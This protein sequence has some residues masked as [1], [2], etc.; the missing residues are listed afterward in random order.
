MAQKIR[1]FEIEFHCNLINK[2]ILT[3]KK[4]IGMKYPRCV[5]YKITR[6]NSYKKMQQNFAHA[7]QNSTKK[8]IATDA[9]AVLQEKFLN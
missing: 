3:M 4:K 2:S 9:N 7:Q 1:I 8:N 5:N 6:R